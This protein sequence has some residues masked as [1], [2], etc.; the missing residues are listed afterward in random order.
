MQKDVIWAIL[1]ALPSTVA[2]EPFGSWTVFNKAV[3]NKET[4]KSLLE[5]LPVTPEPPEYHICKNFLD[6]L[7]DLMK[8]LEINHIFAHADEQVSARLAHILGKFPD[9]YENVMI[10]MGGFHQL[11]LRQRM[12]HKRHACKGYKDWWIDAGIIAAG[13][14]DKAEEAGHY[15]R[16]MRLHKET[17]SGLVQHRVE[18]LTSNFANVSAQLLKA[19]QQLK[20]E[21]NPAH[22]NR[23]MKNANFTKLYRRVISPG[24]GS[25]CQMTVAYLQDVSA[26]LALVSAVREGDLERHLQAEREMLKHCFAFDHINY[27]RYLSFQH[28]FLRDLLRR[29]RPAIT[30]LKSRGFGGSLSINSLF[31]HT[32]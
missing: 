11:R 18:T 27:V 32:W 20:S 15:Y 23:V 9:T 10:L 19:L 28:V 29:N 8:E 25:E 17:F 26:L 13:S 14:A 1:D 4:K 21:P 3:T 12:L 5:Y 7:L 22:L 16:N 30:D 2:S 31:K 6:T 24:Q